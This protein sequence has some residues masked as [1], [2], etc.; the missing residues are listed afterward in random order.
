MLEQWT[1]AAGAECVALFRERTINT[2]PPRGS[3]HG[4]V[5]IVCVPEDNKAEETIAR[6]SIRS[7]QMLRTTAEASAG[8]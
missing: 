7:P 2:Q 6:W 3:N 4:G 1:M 8:K 5:C